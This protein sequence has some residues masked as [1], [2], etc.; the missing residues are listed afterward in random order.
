MAFSLF[1]RVHKEQT[2]NKTQRK[3]YLRGTQHGAQGHFQKALPCFSHLHFVVPFMPVNT[4]NIF[5]D[6]VLHC[7]C[8]PQYFSNWKTQ[9]E[10]KISVYLRHKHLSTQRAF[11]QS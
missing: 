3:V 4:W 9:T 8:K 7:L 10:Q 5:N 11:Y 6:A 1:P 2:V